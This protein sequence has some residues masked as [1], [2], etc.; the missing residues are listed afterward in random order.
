MLW[1]T[2]PLV[3]MFDTD[4]PYHAVCVET[5]SRIPNQDM[6]TTWPCATEAMYLLWRTHGARA[7]HDFWDLLDSQLELTHIPRAGCRRM[8]DLMLRYH[9][10]PMDF[11]DASL[12]VAAEQLGERRI[13][14]FDSHFRAYLIHDKHTFEVLP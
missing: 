2:G 7:Q 14:T 1:D 10:A 6:V 12:V 5:M 9:D 13:F 8:R 4:D 3:A 11:A